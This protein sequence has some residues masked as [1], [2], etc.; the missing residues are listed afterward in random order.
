MG[1]LEWI[2]D[3]TRVD[4]AQC[5]SM[6]I[7]PK[8]FKGKMDVDEDT[9]IL[10]YTSGNLEYFHPD[11]HSSMNM[12]VEYLGITYGEESVKDYLTQYTKAV[13]RKNINKIRE[14]GMAALQAMILDTYEK[15]HAPEA[16]ETKLQDGTLEVT[17]HWCPAVRHLRKTGREVSRWY[18]CTTSV[19]MQTLARECGFAF[20][21]GA[22]DAETGKTSYSFSK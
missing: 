16:V 3:H 14:E 15:E 12:G 8:I 7:D 10:E 9:F 19:V 5:A 22:Y 13:Y 18:P 1:G 20:E 21:M 17:V 11:F 4:K 6:I 2:R